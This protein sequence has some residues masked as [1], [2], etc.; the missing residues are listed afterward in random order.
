L[1][2][3]YWLEVFNPQD[4]EGRSHHKKLVYVKNTR[5]RNI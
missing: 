2:I 5:H 4:K 3:I 1:L